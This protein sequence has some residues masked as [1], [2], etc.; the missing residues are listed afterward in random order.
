MNDAKLPCRTALSAP[1]VVAEGI[2]GH[3][4]EGADHVS[5]QPIAGGFAA[6][7]RPVRTLAPVLTGRG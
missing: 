2:R 4:E 5:V 1:D 3:R 7:D 6:A